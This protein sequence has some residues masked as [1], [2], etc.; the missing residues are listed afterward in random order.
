MK[1]FLEKL[2]GYV[3][4]IAI[5]GSFIWSAI[6]IVSTREKED[7]PDTAVVR[8]GHWQLE[9]GFREAMKVIIAEYEAMHPGVRIV[10]DNI[11]EK[12]YPQWVTTQLMGQ[13]APDLLEMGQ[14]DR[15]I[16]LGY[17]NRYFLP[18][19]EVAGQPNP[20]N[21]GTDLEGV[22]YRNTFKDG[23][24]AGYIEELQ[25][26]MQVPISQ[27]TVR[28]FYNKDLLKKLTGLDKPPADFREFLNVCEKIASQKA[29]NGKP[30]IPMS[31]LMSNWESRMFHPLT[32]S[33]R[34]KA[35]SNRDGWVGAD[36][37]YLAFRSGV[38]NWD[39][40]PLKKRL[41][42][43]REIV[44]YLPNGF[45]GLKRD[46]HVFMFVQQ[47][48]VFIST[49]TWEAGALRQQAEGQFELGVA[50]TPL[51]SSDDPV[52][53]YLVPGPLYDSTTTSC[54]FSVNRS[55][56]HPE[57]AID[58]L[59][60]LTSQKANEKFNSIT[61][62][63]PAIVGAETEGFMKQFEPRFRGVYGTVNQFLNVGPGTNV[64]WSQVYS[65]MQSASLKYDQAGHVI[66]DF[67]E[68]YAELRKGYENFYLETGLEDFTE[69]AQR[70]THRQAE[71]NEQLIAGVRG[72]MLTSKTTPGESA[73]VRH[74]ALVRNRQLSTDYLV[75]SRF[76]VIDGT[77]PFPTPYE[78]TPEALARIRENLSGE[79]NSPS[80]PAAT[81]SPSPVP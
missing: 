32:F 37:L 56:K 19:T 51:P 52:Y 31:G 38:L 59:L 22:P 16:L 60:Y 72:R 36:E 80:V 5:I 49:G 53:G 28:M 12:T 27:H 21:R 65:Q 75:A 71:R 46:E 63:I 33:F 8:I 14:I 45:V 20:Y 64:K 1:Y 9:P 10:L 54:P 13:T 23:M 67:D 76:A 4:F 73:W 15:N 44:R 61:S 78:Y 18:L 34:E 74:R 17:Y 77:R 26:I 48:S 70:D 55:S 3:A 25:E 29:P 79:K 6:A 35:D 57:V 68:Q 69:K 66:D 2:K 43:V 7:P 47:Q 50:D 24:L 11:P 40:D 81:A 41:Q 58:F 39:F 30:Y 42:I 62:W